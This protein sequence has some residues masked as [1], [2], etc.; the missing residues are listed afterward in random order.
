MRHCS[1]ERLR[2]FAGR[3]SETF[4]GSAVQAVVAGAHTLAFTGV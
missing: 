2:A 3:L 1:I 4:G